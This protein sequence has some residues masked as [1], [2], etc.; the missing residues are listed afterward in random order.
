LRS[1]A[2]EEILLETVRRSAEK[3]AIEGNEENWF[4]RK[5]CRRISSGNTRFIRIHR[6]VIVNINCVCEIRLE[7]RS[8]GWVLVGNGDRVRMS[9]TDWPKGSCREPELIFGAARRLRHSSLSLRSFA[10]PVDP[11]RLAEMPLM[12][13][14]SPKPG[15]SVWSRA[16]NGQTRHG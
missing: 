12:E 14:T 2:K 7:G 11:N 9:G 3:S 6:S 13:T 8:E 1:E 5:I 10:S 15:R 16:I 4:R